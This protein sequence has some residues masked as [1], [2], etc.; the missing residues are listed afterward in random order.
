MLI[1]N[2]LQQY[3]NHLKMNRRQNLELRKI[4]TMPIRYV[5]NIQEM[6]AWHILAGCGCFLW[7]A[8]SFG[9]GGSGEFSRERNG[10]RR[11][12]PGE[13][14]PCIARQGIFR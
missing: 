13:A 1:K 2:M 10:G 11:N 8:A 5:E 7:F 6:S 14:F 12:R 9:D 4:C 3:C